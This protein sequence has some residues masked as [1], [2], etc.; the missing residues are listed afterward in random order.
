M[1]VKFSRQPFNGAAN[2]GK[3]SSKWKIRMR[4][5]IDD[6]LRFSYRVLNGFKWTFVFC[7]SKPFL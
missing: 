2:S 5:A 7:A 6:P 1:Q 3:Q 4:R